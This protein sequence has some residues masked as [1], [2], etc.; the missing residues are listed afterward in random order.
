M[1]GLAADSSSPSFP[2]TSIIKDFLNAFLS[3]S[4][5]LPFSV[6]WNL[7]S[8]SLSVGEMRKSFLNLTRTFSSVTFSDSPE[9]EG[10]V[11]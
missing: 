3:A 2:Y 8:I 5:A 7:V 9:T 10:S 6:W 11:A 1:S 4:H